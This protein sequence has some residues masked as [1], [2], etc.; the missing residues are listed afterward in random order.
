MAPKAK[1]RL[2]DQ[3]PS[4]SSS[5]EQEV[6]ESQDEEEQEDEQSEEEESGEE[7]E[8]DEPK[9]A[10]PIEK[11]LPTQKPVQTPQKPQT[12]SESGTENGS[13]SE[14]ESEAESDQSQPSPSGSDFTVKPSFPAKSAPSKPPA[15]RPQET[16][17][18]PKEKESRKKK[19]KIAK[20]EE[21]KAAATPRS[22]WSDED[23]VALLKG[24]AEYKAQKGTEPNADMSAFHEFIKGKLQAD[25]SKSQLS[26]KL[27]R[28]KKKFLTNVKDGEDPVFSKGQDY[29][30]FEYSKKIWGAPVSGKGDAGNSNGVKEN[31]SNSINGKAK[32]NLAV[33]NSAEPKKSAK[34]SSFTKTKD[35]E[36]HKEGEKE[37]QVAVKEVVKED[38]VKGGDQPEFQSRYPCLAASFESMAGLSTMYPNATNYLK[39]NMSLIASDKAKVL[40]EKWKKLHDDEAA[41]MAKRLDLIA[42]HYRLVVDAMKGN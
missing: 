13:G 3:P 27:R 17:Q 38:I 37:K 9:T 22:L 8:E 16:Q 40:E 34:D 20:E 33:K 19:P 4:A 29:L 1:S 42:E 6:E 30:V 11:K 7:T 10:P 36:K 31:V 26:D 15:K 39:E 14:S 24:I 2:V 5:E 23:Q 32:K 35:A 41:L 12:S 18:N 25:V 28:L 21:K